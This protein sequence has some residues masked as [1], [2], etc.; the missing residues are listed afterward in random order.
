MDQYNLKLL[1]DFGQ[2]EIPRYQRAYSWG[3]KQREQLIEDLRDSNGKY[4]LG[5]FLFEKNEG[6]N[7]IRVIDGQQRL[8]TLVI[9]FSS[10]CAELAQR[11]EKYMKD[12]KRIR[13]TYLMDSFTSQRRLKTVDYDDTFFMNEVVDRRCFVPECELLSASQRHIR[14]CREYFDNVFSKESSDVLLE[15]ERLLTNANVTYFMVENKVEAVQIFAFSNDRGKPLS[16]L[17]VLKSFF[18]LQIYIQSEKQSDNIQRLYDSFA[19]IYHSVVNI[20]TREDDVLRYF[21]MAYGGKGFYSEDYLAEIKSYSKKGGVEEIIR[22]TEQLSRAFH[23]VEFVEKDN[24]FDMTN[25]RRL[26]RMAQSWPLLIKAKVISN[27]EDNTW[28]RLVRLLENVTFRSLI[29]G[30]RA[31]IESRLHQLLVNFNDDSSLN[32]RIDIF[33]EGMKNDY[34]NDSE[35]HNAID[36]GYIYGRRKACTYLL[37]RYE[38]HLCPRDYSNPKVAWEDIMNSQ[39]LDHIAPQ[40]PK[41]GEPLASGY[42]NYDGDN[43]IESEGWLHSIGNLVLM[44]QEQ[45]SSIGNRNFVEVKLQSY[46][47]ANLMWQQKEIIN[48]VSDRNNPVWDKNAIERRGNHLI[49]EAIKIWSF[50]NI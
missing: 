1:F 18:M 4:Y 34:W 6:N 11:D 3:K 36:S 29:R 7:T 15:W 35:L 38:Q 24:S 33:K 30:G 23:Y 47:N 46:E 41:D 43:G 22:F 50:D 39:S 13:H 49:D 10:L 16:H 48:Y 44:S 31:D 40:H 20:T 45:N 8:T 28:I 19:K 9:F 26:D 25:L 12:V 27:V 32:Q 2:L 5:H 17:E 14:H 37:W 42:G 21:W